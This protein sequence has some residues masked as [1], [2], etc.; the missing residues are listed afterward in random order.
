MKIFISDLKINMLLE[1]LMSSP[2]YIQVYTQNIQNAKL[3]LKAWKLF[4]FMVVNWFHTQL[5]LMF[6]E[7]SFWFCI[8]FIY[9]IIFS[10]SLLKE[11]EAKMKWDKR[12]LIILVFGMLFNSEM[13]LKPVH[14][15]YFIS[16]LRKKRSYYPV[17]EKGLE[18]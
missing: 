11:E 4:M 6:T 9:N 10:F 3:N 15:K 18:I 7:I 5:I 2:F 17:L 14:L 1:Q 16:K 8:Y 12:F 13:L